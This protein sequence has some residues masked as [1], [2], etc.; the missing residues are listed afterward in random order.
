MFCGDAIADPL[1]GLEAASAVAE[2]LGR[3]GGELIE[4]SMAAVAATYAALPTLPSVCTHPAPPP[5]ASAAG[6]RRRRARRR[7]RRRAP[8]GRRKTLPVML[9]RRATLLDGDGPDI[10]VGERIDEV[11]DDLVA[12]QRGG[13]A[14]RGRR[15]RAARPARPPR[16]RALGGLRAGFVFRRAA[17]G[18]HQS[19]TGTDC[20]RTPRR[21]PT[22]GF[23]PSAITSRSPASWT[24]PLWTPWCPTF[25]CASSTAAAR[26]GSST[27]PRWA[28][29]AWP[30][31]PTG[32]C[33]APTAAGRTRCCGAKPTWPNSAA[34][35]PR[36]AS[37]ASPTPPP[38][39]T[40]TTWSR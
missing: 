6:R 28:G 23:A 10:R 38:T 12:R 5:P 24:G 26:C 32:G 20:C 31:I 11:G 14:R 1:T 29:S 17:R 33:A 2:S 25:R 9:I 40:P 39:S 18:Q 13:C 21:V 7:Q 19:R 22:G 15:H 36:P 8:Y 27:P 35:S 4:V 3:G 34:G 37:P 16:A 30:N